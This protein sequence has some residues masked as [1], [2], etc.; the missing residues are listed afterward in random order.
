MAFVNEKITRE[1]DINLFNSFHFLNCQ[2]K[3]E[4]LN[5]FLHF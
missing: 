4:K 2:Y 3:S 5:L 1:E